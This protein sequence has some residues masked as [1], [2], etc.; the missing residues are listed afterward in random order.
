[1]N[2]AFISIGTNMGDREEF[3]NRA[4]TSLRAAEG[5]ESVER[6]SIYE[7]APVGVTDQ[8]DFLNIVVRV[9]TV[10]TP[11]ELLAGCQRIES[12]LGR[13][14]TIRWGPRTADLDILLYN[15]DSIDSETLTIPHPRMQDR[16]F[17]LIPLTEL[18]PECIDPITGRRF[19]EEQAMQDGGVELWKPYRG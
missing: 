15:D 6:S 17:V 4:V 11:F 7:T 14:R 13:V 1:M 9:R 5:I 12:E 8:A 19:R 2:T 10:L 18:A 3:L 16:A